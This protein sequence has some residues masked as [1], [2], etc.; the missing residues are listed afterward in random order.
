MKKTILIL[1]PVLLGFVYV[2]VLHLTQT[3]NLY[4][5]EFG[6]LLLFY[7][8]WI[9]LTGFPTLAAFALQCFTCNTTT[10]LF[11]RLLPTAAVV[12]ILVLE[13]LN[14]LYGLLLFIPSGLL[15]I[16]RWLAVPFVLA[17]LVA[18]WLVKAEGSGES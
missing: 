4:F 8:V 6:I 16:S 15:G 10:N 13:C 9:L 12:A 5:N 11:L 14:P 17:G 2:I 1:L 18:G 3:G 7:F